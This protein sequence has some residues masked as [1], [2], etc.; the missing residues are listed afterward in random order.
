[1]DFHLVQNLLFLLSF[2]SAKFFS[3]L[4][5]FLVSSYSFSKNILG[6]IV[7][8]LS[9]VYKYYWFSGLTIQNRIKNPWAGK[10]DDKKSVHHN[11]RV[12]PQAMTWILNSHFDIVSI[13]LVF[14]FLR[15]QMIK[16]NM[17]KGYGVKLH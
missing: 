8:F 15:P 13:T 16:G 9:K 10:I 3:K 2:L 1:M 7:I 11:L 14:R 5:N 6:F 4:F 17:W 12:I